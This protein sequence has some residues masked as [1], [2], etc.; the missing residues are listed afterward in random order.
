MDRQKRTRPSVTIHYAQTLDGRIATSTGN[1][2]W[3]SGDE[4]LQL[5]HQ[6]RAAHQAVLVGVGT[7]LADNPRLTVRLAPGRSPSRIVA[8]CLLR[9]PLDSNVLSD[10][11]AETFLAVTSDAPVDRVE[12][13]RRAGAEILVID[14]DKA[15]HVDLAVLLQR[16][17]DVGVESVLI[18]GGQGIIT[19]A[20]QSRLVDRLVVCIAPKVV[21]TGIDA[22][23]D[24]SIRCL[25]DALTFASTSFTMLGRDVIFDGQLDPSFVRQD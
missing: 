22:I 9:S 3:V 7:V 23:G 19:S 12:A 21:G 17:A 14:R 25:D 24:L 10:G 20:L 1:S 6:L 15:G 18:E 11:A 13:A 4:S 5:A 16:L 8:D 2:Q